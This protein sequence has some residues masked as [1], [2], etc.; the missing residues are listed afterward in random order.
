MPEKHERPV[1]PIVA[2]PRTDG[3]GGAI[4]LRN[5]ADLTPEIYQAVIYDGAKVALHPAALER[6]ARH[7]RQFLQ[8]LETGVICYGVN[9]GL[10]AL[11]KKDLSAEDRAALPRHILLGRAAAI[12][13][14]FARPIVR[15]TLLI[16]LAQ[17]LD[18]ASAVTPDLCDF[19]VARIND[20]FAPYVPSEG[21]GMAGEIIPL[22][23]LA[24]ALI[25]EGFVLG[26]GNLPQPTEL[27]CQQ[28]G[29]TPYDPAPK[30]G[31]S[32]INGTAIG[33]A[34]AADLLLQLRATLIQAELV[35]AASIEGLAAPLEP[36]DALVGALRRDRGL[37]EACERLRDLL[38]ESDI[39]R[40]QR[41]APVSFRVTPQ[42]H[43]AAEQA[44]ADLESAIADEMISTGDNPAFIA[45][46]EGGVGGRLLHCGNFHAAALTQAVE[47]AAL[48]QMQLGLLAERRLHR[49]L[50]QRASGLAPQLAKQPGLDAGLVTLHKAVLGL[51]AELRALAVPPSLMHGE[52]SFGQED[53][54][55]MLFPALDRLA[56]IDGLNRRILTYELYTALV[57]VDERQEA[58]EAE[59]PSIA[60][61]ALRSRIR[62]QIPSYA[63]DRSYGPD[64]ERLRALLFD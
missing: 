26:P 42:I 46:E 7:R 28:H 32:L 37:I 45:D 6:L 52:S 8:H 35:A 39:T 2:Q 17:F 20:G 47:A 1:E 9:T 59:K 22:C 64:I 49:L 27:W 43:A 63:G 30:E 36:Y 50:D 54:M 48:A 3:D 29:V 18:G 10:G 12:G 21:L 15:G 11:S 58:D 19:L 33:P 55:T 34:Y 4:V 60:V 57:A 56:R 23:H 51:S 41:Q 44:L 24:Q 38:R 31:L 13:A 53:V 14:P 16:R 40:Q 62:Q 61:A 5:S 25:G